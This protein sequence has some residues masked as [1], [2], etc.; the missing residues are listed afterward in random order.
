M[1]MA[2]NLPPIIQLAIFV[3]TLPES[4]AARVSFETG[5]FYGQIFHGEAGFG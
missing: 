5:L 2:A 4:R 3:R 1:D